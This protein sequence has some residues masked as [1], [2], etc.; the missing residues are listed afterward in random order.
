M[1]VN[2]WLSASAP[3]HILSYLPQQTKFGDDNVFTGISL[4]TGGGGV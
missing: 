4:L 3:Q 1:A 2:F